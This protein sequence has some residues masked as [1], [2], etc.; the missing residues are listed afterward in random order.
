MF[1]MESLLQAWC[2]YIDRVHAFDKDF[3]IFMDSFVLKTMNGLV[4][5][6]TMMI[7]VNN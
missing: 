6:L 2:P 5:L 4:E 3:H 1:G 7:N